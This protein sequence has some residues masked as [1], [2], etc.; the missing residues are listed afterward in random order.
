MSNWTRPVLYPR[1][2]SGKDGEWAVSALSDGTVLLRSGSGWM[3]RSTD[4]G[5]TFGNVSTPHAVPKDGKL[6]VDGGEF[7]CADECGSWTVF[8]LLAPD[9]GLPAGVFT[10]TDNVV[11]HS[12]DMA[13]SFHRFGNASGFAGRLPRVGS[14]TGGSEFFSQSQVYRRK[15]GVFLHGARWNTAPCD[16]LAGSQIM[17]WAG[18]AGTTSE[19]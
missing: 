12:S 7:D 16:D 19:L 2:V 3:A 5:A 17:W 14:C 9:H 13:R 8:E 4:R 11:W 10:F 15:D 18:L 1:S 6:L